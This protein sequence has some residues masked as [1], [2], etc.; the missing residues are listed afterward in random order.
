MRR[1]RV[2]VGGTKAARKRFETR[3][4]KTK[5]SARRRVNTIKKAKDQGVSTIWLMNEDIEPYCWHLQ[6]ETVYKRG[7]Q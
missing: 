6:S 1:Y 3:I 7:K 4:Y 5:A 2:V